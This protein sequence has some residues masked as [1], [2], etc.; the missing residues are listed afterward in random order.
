[1]CPQLHWWVPRLTSAIPPYT[2]QLWAAQPRQSSSPCTAPSPGKGLTQAH[3]TFPQG[4][5]A[6]HISAQRAP[7]QKNQVMVPAAHTEDP[8]TGLM[9]P[10]AWHGSKGTS[11]HAHPGKEVGK[12]H[13][14]P[15]SKHPWVWSSVPGQHQEGSGSGQAASPTLSHS[16][17]ASAKRLEVNEGH[18]RC[19]GP[20]RGT[21][22]PQRDA[23]CC[24]DYK[25][26]SVSPQGRGS[27]WSTSVPPLCR[28]DLGIASS[29]H[30]CLGDLDP[31][32]EWQGGSMP[33]Y[34]SL[35]GL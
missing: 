34:M 12:P 25:D 3:P 14:S 29:S 19:W 9:Q 8:S 27:L 15:I 32:T 21:D 4:L 10:P 18:G 7:S 26:H 16:C 1:M 6:P 17:L 20:Q 22:V 2:L 33:G 5:P 13:G 30:H 31:R 35:L 11:H 23:C 24:K 28:W